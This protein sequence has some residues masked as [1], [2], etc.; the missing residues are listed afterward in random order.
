MNIE[1]QW[2]SPD[3]MHPWAINAEQPQGGSTSKSM[4]LVDLALESLRR[5]Q[6]QVAVRRAYMYMALGEQLPDATIAPLQ[7]AIALCR[8]C[9]LSAMW[10]AASNWAAVVSGDHPGVRCDKSPLNFG[11]HK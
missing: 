8:S 3:Q 11:G 7:S 2:R 1:T 10:D 4:V 5:G 6:Y 9:E